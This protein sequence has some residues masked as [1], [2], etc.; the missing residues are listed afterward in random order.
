MSDLYLNEQSDYSEENTSDNEDFRST[1][2]RSFLQVFL[3]IGVLKNFANLKA[4]NVIKKRLRHICIP[5]KFEKFLRRSFVYRTH[6]VA[7]F[8]TKHIFMLELPI[9]YKLK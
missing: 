8:Q 4:C 9:Y 7:T 2:Y 3:K 5:V 1:N 6:S